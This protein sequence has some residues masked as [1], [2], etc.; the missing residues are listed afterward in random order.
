MVPYFSSIDTSVI[1]PTIPGGESY[2]L[3]QIN[4]PPMEVIQQFQRGNCGVNKSKF[5]SKYKY[6][7]T[8]IVFCRGVT[9]PRPVVINGAN[10]CR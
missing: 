6:N 10:M 1:I 3:A 2:I 7:G 9:P 5:I 8:M 4:Q